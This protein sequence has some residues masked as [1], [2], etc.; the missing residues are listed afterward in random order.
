ML[1][2]EYRGVGQTELMIANLPA[3]QC[4]IVSP[5]AG[6]GRYIAARVHKANPGKRRYVTV[7]HPSDVQKL[8]GL[9]EPI[10]FDHSFF[11]LASKET[12]AKALEMAIPCSRMAAWQ[13]A[14]DA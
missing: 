14:A 11:G 13:E 7:R 3:R 1:N 2:P 8:S 12:A 5:A 6:I 10:F 9:C 4:T